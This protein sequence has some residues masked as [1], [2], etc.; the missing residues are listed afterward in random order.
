MNE[1]RLH[2]PNQDDGSRNT[3]PRSNHRPQSDH[4]TEWTG[5]PAQDITTVNN[6]TN[7]QLVTNHTFVAFVYSLLAMSRNGSDN[8]PAHGSPLALGVSRVTLGTMPPPQ[9]SGRLS[10]VSGAG[11]VDDATRRKLLQNI[12]AAL[13]GIPYLVIGDAALAEHG[14]RRP[15]EGLDILLGEGCSAQHAESLLVKQ[16]RGQIFSL[17]RG[18]TGLVHTGCCSGHLPAHPRTLADSRMQSF[19]VQGGA[20]CPLRLL[21]NSD[22]DVGA[23]YDINMSSPKGSTAKIA[24]IECLLNAKAHVWQTRT[25]SKEQDQSRHQSDASDIL[26]CLRKLQGR[27]IDQRRLSWVNTNDFRLQFQTENPQACQL[28]EGTGL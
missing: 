3:E 16:S 8:L 4:L 15:L 6:L 1:Q 7:R 27:S 17:G 24:S 22:V 20:V 14:S 18:K 5:D 19:C 23:I 21:K 13:Q 11:T 28:F 12:H 9:Q 25:R 10:Q 2:C 26:F